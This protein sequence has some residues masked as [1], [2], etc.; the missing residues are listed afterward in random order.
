L[1]VVE[2]GTMLPRI[3]DDATFESV[4]VCELTLEVAEGGIM[5]PL[6]PYENPDASYV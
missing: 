3:P 5:L 6:I 2:G 1:K 4:S